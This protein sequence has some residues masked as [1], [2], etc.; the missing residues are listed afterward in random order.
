M[1]KIWFTDKTTGIEDALQDLITWGNF[2]KEKLGCGIYIL[3]HMNNC[4][5]M[6]KPLEHKHTWRRLKELLFNSVPS[7]MEFICSQSLF[8]WEFILLPCQGC[9]NGSHYRRQ[10]LR[11]RKDPPLVF[12]AARS[13]QFKCAQP[14]SAVNAPERRAQ[15]HCP[16]CKSEVS[17][18][19]SVAPWNS[20][21]G[22]VK[23]R[24]FSKLAPYLKAE[25]KPL[26]SCYYTGP[27]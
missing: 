4:Q 16:W 22:K 13:P 23:T 18:P 1:I 21:R 12:P 15:S 26:F 10:E 27:A 3:F 8:R 20:S 2:F 7:W 19:K 17:P 9:I 25:I 24:G 6:D 14:N 11:V 5:D